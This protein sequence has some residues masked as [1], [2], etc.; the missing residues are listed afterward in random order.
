VIGRDGYCDAAWGYGIR[1]DGCKGFRRHDWPA[2]GMGC[3]PSSQYPVD[4]NDNRRIFPAARR[5]ADAEICFVDPDRWFPVFG[6]REGC[7]NFHRV[8]E[9]RAVEG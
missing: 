5:Q 8:G 6:L 1:W 3:W 2:H 7:L 9:L 4:A